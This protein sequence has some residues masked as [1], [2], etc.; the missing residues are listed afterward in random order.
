LRP[1]W[2]GKSAKR[3]FAVQDPAIHVFLLAKSEDVD[4]RDEPGHDEREIDK[5]RT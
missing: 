2:P 4:A 3:V 5:E 1:S